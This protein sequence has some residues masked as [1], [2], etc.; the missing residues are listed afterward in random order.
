MKWNYKNFYI[1]HKEKP[2]ILNK[3][4]FNEEFEGWKYGPI[5]REIRTVFT[6]DGMNAETEDIKSDSKYIINNVILEY[7]ALASWKLSELSHKEVSWL[8]S[9]RGLKEDAKK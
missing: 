9:R 2:Y 6:E 5:S 4:L 8:N 3:P 7:G 1:F